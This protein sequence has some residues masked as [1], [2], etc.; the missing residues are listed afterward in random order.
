MITGKEPIGRNVGHEG[1]TLYQRTLREF[2]C[3]MIAGNVDNADNPQGCAEYADKLV[4]AYINQLNK[5]QS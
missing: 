4:N 3:A 1:E 5:Q 2:M